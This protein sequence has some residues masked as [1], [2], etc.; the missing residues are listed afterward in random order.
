V[1]GASLSDMAGFAPMTDILSAVH[2]RSHVRLF[3]S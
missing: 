2:Q 3:T 1:R